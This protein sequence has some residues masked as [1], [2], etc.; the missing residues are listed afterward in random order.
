MIPSAGHTLRTRA[1][2][3]KRG[4]DKL[5]VC[6]CWI[7]GLSLRHLQ[8][9]QFFA[10]RVRRCSTSRSC[11]TAT[12]ARCSKWYGGVK[13]SEKEKMVE[14]LEKD[15]EEHENKLG[16]IE[17]EIEAEDAVRR[18]GSQR[19]IL[20]QKKS[21]T[22]IASL[23]S[24]TAVGARYAFR[25]RKR[26]LHTKKDKVRLWSTCFSIDTMFLNGKDS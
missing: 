26:T 23:T 7:C 12:H 14:E 20:R 2:E 19:R 8:H 4:S 21:T 18:E 17:L 16:D 3:C 15:V 13:G 1:Q 5:E 11:K 10:G 25:P 24:R 6:T 22:V 9:H